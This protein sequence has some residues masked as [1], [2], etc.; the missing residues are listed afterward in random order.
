MVLA[1][2]GRH[3]TGTVKMR[4]K[5]SSMVTNILPSNG[6]DIVHSLGRRK[7]ITVI[8]SKVGSTP[9]LAETSVKVTVNTKASITVST[10]SIMLVGDQLDSMPTT[11]HLDQTALEGVRRGLF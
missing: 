11:V 7:G 9:T 3:A 10:T 1:N 5:I 4:T 6:R 8:K 2:S